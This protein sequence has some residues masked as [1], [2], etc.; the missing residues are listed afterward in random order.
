MLT[1]TG[2]QA[3]HSIFDKDGN[4]NLCAQHWKNMKDSATQKMW[5]VFDELGAFIAVCWH[6]FC[7][8]IMDMVQ[9]SKWLCQLDNLTTY[10]EGL[11][12]KD[13]KGC[14]HAFSKSNALAP[15]TRY[16]SIFHRRQAIACYFEHNDEME[17]YTNL[18]KFL[19]N[20]YK[21]A[22]NLLCNGCTTLEQL[23]C[24]LGSLLCELVE[25]TLQMEY[26]QW[27]VSLKGSRKSLETIL[28]TWTIVTTHNVASIQSD[29]SAT[30]KVETM[31]HH[32]QENYE[33]DLKAVQEL[34]GHLGITCHWVLEDKEWQAAAH[35]VA[36]QKYQ[37]ALDNIECLVVSW[38]FELSKMNQSSTGYKLFKHIGKALQA[39]LAAICTAL[40]QYN[41][42]AKALSRQ[43]LDF[44]EVMEYAFLADF[45]LLW[46]T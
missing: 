28:S 20:N 34:E 38:I 33:K 21:Q 46:D 29:G 40:L 19:L 27:L 22:L 11:G 31:H 26:W 42:A 14:E 30:R 6:G 36:N 2:Q 35:L 44:D 1:H 41:T 32:I 39:C 45:N 13:L 43:T 5:N 24:E 25:E 16:V 10:V 7:L 37:Q 17:V 8:L 15:S 9:S 3:G 12:L 23:M 4:G 18:R